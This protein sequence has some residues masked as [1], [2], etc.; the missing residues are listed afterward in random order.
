MGAWSSIPG[1]RYEALPSVPN[2]LE[3]KV[4][5]FP[6]LS[7][8]SVNFHG[9]KPFAYE[10]FGI[11]LGQE[12][13]LVF[14]GPRQQVISAEFVDCRYG[15]ATLHQR[16]AAELS[17]DSE[18]LLVIP[19]GV[20]HRLVGLEGIFTLNIPKIFLPIK[21]ANPDY[22]PA[23]DV[24]NV[25]QDS[26][27]FPVVR[28]NDT[29]ASDEAYEVLVRLQKLSIAKGPHEFPAVEEFCL[30][31]GGRARVTFRRR[32]KRRTQRA[33]FQPIEGIEGLGWR[34]NLWVRTGR[35]SG[36]VVFP[37]LN[38][39]HLIDHGESYYANDSFGLH[40][41][42][43]D[44]LTYF[45]PRKQRVKAFFVD[46]R[47]HSPTRHQEACIEFFPDPLRTLVIPPGVAHRFEH[48]ENVFTR[49][50]YQFCLPDLKTMESDPARY[51]VRNDVIDV[52]IGQKPYPIV[53]PMRNAAPRS[54]YRYL[55][56]R[57]SETLAEGVKNM[58][59]AS[60]VTQDDRGRTLKVTIRKRLAS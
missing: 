2:G 12:D 39:F 18:R 10:Q 17:P 54:F 24:L 42:Q 20:A 1:L 56:K 50:D 41:M 19:R 36:F 57:M 7:P 29:E 38:P 9:E 59:P 40:L 47:A 32:V 44:L 15:S 21:R 37:Q 52:P 22:Q 27:S 26:R 53:C 6:V 46:C 28:V 35:D 55:A 33:N 5:P 51:D 14:L 8:S 16:V 31:S 58:A 43:E 11:H 34:A 48:L 23:A 30:A 3:S 4:V 49:D 25:R 13:R 45:G 60:T